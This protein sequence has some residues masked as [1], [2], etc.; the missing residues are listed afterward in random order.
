MSW[1][2]YRPSGILICRSAIAQGRGAWLHVS[3]LQV[4]ERVIEC[5]GHL[6]EGAVPPYMT[7]ED[8]ERQ[9]LAMGLHSYLPNSNCET[10]VCLKRGLKLKPVHIRFSFGVINRN[11]NRVLHD[12]YGCV[13]VESR[14]SRLT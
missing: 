2:T 4:F 11:T 8:T 3:G 10:E 12:N 7:L 14:F 13:T 9:D 6:N 1:S 5:L